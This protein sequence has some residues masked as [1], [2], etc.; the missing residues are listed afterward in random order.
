[1]TAVNN[2]VP[3]GLHYSTK[4][5]NSALLIWKANTIRGFSYKVYASTAAEDGYTLIA[6]VPQEKINAHISVSRAAVKYFKVSSVRVEDS[7]ESEKSEA[8]M[9]PFSGDEE[10]Q[11]EREGQT[12]HVNE[13][14]AETAVD[15][16][17]GEWVT[18]FSGNTAAHA[19]HPKAI[20]SMQISS[21]F[22]DGGAL[23]GLSMKIDVSEN[24]DG[25]SPV[26]VFS[27]SGLTVG[28]NEDIAFLHHIKILNDKYFFI[29]FMATT[30]TNATV[31]VEELSYVNYVGSQLA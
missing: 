2:N 12:I 15:L 17:A 6:T 30:A 25:S 24:A 11:A 18:A 31:K 27:E 20:V 1:M 5:E 21:A 13:S 3:F 10:S 7:V 23:T 22:A 26:T 4:I 29:K 28:L 8:I 19:L 16:I 9:I 14:G